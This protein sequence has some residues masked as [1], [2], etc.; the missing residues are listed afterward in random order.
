MGCCCRG[1]TPEGVEAMA[2]VEG[3]LFTIREGYQRDIKKG[4]RCETQPLRRVLAAGRVYFVITICPLMRQMPP[5]RGA[6]M[7]LPA[8]P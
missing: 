2:H 6:R 4:L 3:A 7:R 5:L 1:C 8:R